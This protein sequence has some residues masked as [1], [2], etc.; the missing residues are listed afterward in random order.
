MLLEVFMGTY[1][2]LKMHTL[3]HK[4][5]VL[6]G[7]QCFEICMFFL[8]WPTLKLVIFT[9]IWS[10]GCLKAWLLFPNVGASS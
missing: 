1:E 9:Q 6:S 8:C 5:T 3:F 4:E 10:K 2:V 7:C